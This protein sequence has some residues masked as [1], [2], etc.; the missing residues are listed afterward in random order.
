[1]EDNFNI[2][3]PKLKTYNIEDDQ[4]VRM[5]KIEDKQNG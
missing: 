5:T 1:M 4:N 3:R 2:R